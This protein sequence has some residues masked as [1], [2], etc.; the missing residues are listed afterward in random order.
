MKNSHPDEFTPA[1][2]LKCTVANFLPET[3]AYGCH[4]ALVLAEIMKNRQSKNTLAP[5]V[6]TMKNTTKHATVIGW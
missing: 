4:Y 5:T 1:L 2:L 6:M 3:S